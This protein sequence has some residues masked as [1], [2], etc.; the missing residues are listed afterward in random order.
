[1]EDFWDLL[2]QLM[3]HGTNTLYFVFIFLFSIVIGTFNLTCS[4]K[5]GILYKVEKQIKRTSQPFPVVS[6]RMPSPGRCRNPPAGLEGS[7]KNL[8]ALIS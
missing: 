6:L 5:R 1:M 4:A 7:S 3:K 8:W 2:F